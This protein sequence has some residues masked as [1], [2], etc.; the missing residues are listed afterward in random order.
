MCDKHQVI[1]E[2]CEPKGSCTVLKSNGSCERVVDFN[3]S[4]HDAIE[5]IF[6]AVKFKSKYILEADLTKCF[7]RISHTELLTKIATFPKARRQ[8]KAWLKAGILDKQEVL[9]PKEG[10]PQGGIC[11]PLLANIALHGMEYELKKH[12][13]KWKEIQWGIKPICLIKYA[14]DFVIIHENLK[15]VERCKEFIEKWL[16]NIGLELNQEKTK[17]SHTLN[18]HEKSKP[19]FNFL[20]FYIRQYPKGKNQSGKTPQGKKLGF[21]TLIKPSEEKI[22]QHYSKL[23]NVIN[24]HKS[25]KQKNLILSLT[26]IIKG[27]ANYYKTVCS[28]KTFSKV[29]NLLKMKLFK[30]GWRRHPNK[31]KKWVVNKYWLREGRWRFGYEEEGKLHVL[32]WHTQ[33]EI[34]RH[35]KVKN[36]AS[37]YDGNSNYWASRMGKHPEIKASIARLLK[38]QKGKCNHCGLTFR[39]E[40]NIHR[41]HIIPSAAGGNGIKDNLQLLHKHCHDV[42][43]KQD[44][45][46]IK[47]FKYHQER[48]KMEKKIQSQ[49]EKS[50]W[51]WINDIPT[52]I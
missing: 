24:N 14:D 44:L 45:E 31:G 2:P 21:K 20:G 9:F 46:I 12:T 25:A 26:P 28:K 36:D 23:A 29:E 47:S 35:I 30:W 13:A 48:E 32:P 40:D 5:A 10:T 17:I 19:G 6:N 52:M 3:R 41:D 16:A 42:K 18:K 27:W 22:R 49:F 43:T 11:S 1:E 38:K 37:P 8:I 7:D 39:S 50:K 34:T 51:Q 4:C 15:V 33:T